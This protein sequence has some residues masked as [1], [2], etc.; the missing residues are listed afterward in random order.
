[1]A[2]VA[3]TIIEEDDPEEHELEILAIKA[4]TGETGCGRVP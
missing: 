1:M 2:I 4:E 3:R